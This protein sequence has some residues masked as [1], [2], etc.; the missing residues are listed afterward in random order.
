MM[1]MVKIG[2]NGRIYWN[3]ESESGQRHKFSNQRYE[4]KRSICCF[5]AWPTGW[6]FSIAYTIRKL[7][8]FI[9]LFF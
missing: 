1:L 4:D 9:I 8:L 6:L 2:R 7:F 3:A 5:E